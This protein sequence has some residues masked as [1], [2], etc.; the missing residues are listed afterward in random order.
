LTTRRARK[1]D[2]LPRSY[3]VGLAIYAAFFFAVLYG[4]L[5]MIAVLSFNNSNVTGFP[6]RGFT[7]AWYE[8]VLATPEFITAFGS[9]IAIGLLAALAATSLALCLALGF[10]RHFPLKTAVFNLVLT[11]IVMPGIVGG[12]V[13]LLFFGYLNLRPSLWTTVLVAH[14]NYVLPFAF[15]ALYPRVHNFD[16][17]LEEAAMDL[18]AQSLGVFWYVVFPIIRPGLI[19]TFLFSF[20]L[21][22]DEFIRTLF[23][24]G[25]DRTV[26]VMF[27]S[28]I[29]DELTPELPAMAVLIILVSATTSLIAVVVSGRAAGVRQNG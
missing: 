18:G 3:A 28:R 22:F 12:I 27:W 5:V 13:L 24:T 15:L 10:R 7:L 6:L 25:Y 26:P 4:P 20:S 14:I 11:P 17:S 16:R 21:S 19:A 23:V 2:A 1:F 9:S 8:K 29:V